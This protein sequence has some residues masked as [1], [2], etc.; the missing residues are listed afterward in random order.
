MS[1]AEVVEA[2]WN[3]CNVLAQ[4]GHGR[5][6]VIALGSRNAH[7]ITLNG[8]LHFELA[9]FQC[10][11]NFFAVLGGNA[12]ANFKNLLHFVAAD[13]LDVTLV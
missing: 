5:L 7:G 12:I 1:V 2:N 11:L 3:F 8:G 6:Q 4:Q 13:F 9:F 10:F